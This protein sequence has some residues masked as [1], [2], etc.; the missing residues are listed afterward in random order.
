M[1]DTG[2][3]VPLY[4]TNPR[5][6]DNSSDSGSKNMSHLTRPEQGICNILS[7]LPGDPRKSPHPPHPILTS[8]QRH[9]PGRP[10]SKE[11]YNKIESLLS[12]TLLL[13]H[14]CRA[15]GDAKRPQDGCFLQQYLLCVKGVRCQVSAG[16]TASCLALGGP[17]SGGFQNWATGR[18]RTLSRDLC[19]LL[20][21]LSVKQWWDSVLSA[22]QMSQ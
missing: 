13:P 6:L 1:F 18:K 19:H 16:E 2:P 12:E 10:L 7:A 20:G 5:G 14:A 15:G 3:S 22:S 17:E 9:S 4:N 8:E 11:T 21:S